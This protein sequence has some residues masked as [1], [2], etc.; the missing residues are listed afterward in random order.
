MRCTLKSSMHEQV[1]LFLSLSFF[2]MFHFIIFYAL[3]HFFGN[4]KATSRWAKLKDFLAGKC[5]VSPYL[6]PF[7]VDISFSFPFF[8]IPFSYFF[9]FLSFSLLLHFFIPIDKFNCT[10]LVGST[11]ALRAFV[12][13][14]FPLFFTTLPRRIMRLHRFTPSVWGGMVFR[15][16]E[17]DCPL[18]LF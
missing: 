3:H 2:H 4:G 14:K 16:S 1:L 8:S 12:P 18:R 7:F 10:F 6:F 17:T 5:F 9:F 11:H 15:L 13:Q